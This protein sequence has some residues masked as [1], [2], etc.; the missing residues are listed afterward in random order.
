MSDIK[1]P[2]LQRIRS[3]LSGNGFPWII[4]IFMLTLT[5]GLWQYSEIQFINLSLD[6]FQSRAEK[7]K[8]VIV[9]RLQNY[10]QALH[11]AAGLFAADDD[12]TRKDWHEY[13]K[14]LNAEKLLP[15][16]QGVGVIEI[17]YK[18]NK[19]Q[20][21]TA[22]RADGISYYSIHPVTDHDPL[23]S[24]VYLEPFSGH[25]IRML[26]YDMYSDPI[27]RSSM[28]QARDSGKITLSR[29][30]RSAQVLNN[31]EQPD[32]LLYLPVYR[33][34]EQLNTVA[35][36]RRA[37]L[38]FVYIPFRADDFMKSIF[39]GQAR[40]VEI[41]LFDGRA[42][43]ENLLY[44]SGENNRATRYATKKELSIDGHIWTVHFRSSSEFEASTVNQLPSIIR[45]GGMALDL[46]LFFL[47]FLN[48]QRMR[49]IREL[50]VRLELSDENFNRLE[51]HL[52]GAVF[53]VKPEFPWQVQYIGHGIEALTGIPQA[54]FLTKEL[55]L[56]RVIHPD[57]QARFT[58]AVTEAQTRPAAFDITLQI[59]REDGRIL[60]GNLRGRIIYDEAG[61]PLWLEGVMFDITRFR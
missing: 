15:G 23:S 57:D 2:V 28:E 58:A 51:E 19:Y 26:G 55:S 9:N 45:F 16:I 61:T 25:N 54:R 33:N 39:A 35:A 13:V 40:D 42:T 44:S 22:V 4:L 53:R 8:N 20:H 46:L 56:D 14:S 36:R 1:T 59:K 48:I 18:K 49:N 32:F 27:L 21:E 29:R 7:H 34:N 47:L 41:D 31:K 38:G 24:V 11:G 43:P 50:T 30:V 5:T 12:V 3:W 52:S 17:V 37:L 6:R 10:I 60:W